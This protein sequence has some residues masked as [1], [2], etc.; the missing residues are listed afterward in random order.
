MRICVSSFPESGSHSNNRNRLCSMVSSRSYRTSIVMIALVTMI[1]GFILAIS[2]G[3]IGTLKWLHILKISLI[4][5]AI[6]YLILGA[7]LGIIELFIDRPYQGQ[8]A[9]SAPIVP[10]IPLHFSVIMTGCILI[11]S[12]AMHYLQPSEPERLV[13]ALRVFELGLGFTTMSAVWEVFAMIKTILPRNSKEAVQNACPNEVETTHKSY[14]PVD[15]MMIRLEDKLC[16]L[17]CKWRYLNQI[18][19]EGYTEKQTEIVREY[20]KTVVELFDLGLDSEFDF[21]CVLPREFMPKVYL[22][23]WGWVWFDRK[24]IWEIPDHYYE[25]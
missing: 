5:N 13:T 20:H 25:K 9:Q 15:P 22:D 16:D 17:A 21:E 1:M 4:E 10:Q 6:A 11:L 7:V 23:K 19:S 12:I 8:L 18:Q 2:T 14:E 3:K 24:S